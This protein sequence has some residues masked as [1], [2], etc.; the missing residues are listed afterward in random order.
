MKSSK[1][2]DCPATG[3]IITSAECGENRQTKYACPESCPF[4]PWS[5]EN[6]DM[7]NEIYDSMKPKMYDLIGKEGAREMETF[8]R[9]KLSDETAV[10]SQGALDR[11]LHFDLDES[12]RSRMQVWQEQNWNGLKN[13]GKLQAESLMKM[14]ISLIEVHHIKNNRLSE[15]V[16]LLHPEEPPILISDYTLA[17]ISSRFDTFL[18]LTYPAP[19][20]TRLH[21]L[22]LPMEGAAG[23]TTLEVVCAIARHLGGPDDLAAVSSWIRKNTHR[24]WQA[25][26]E[27][28]ES[29]YQQKMKGVDARRT[30]TVYKAKSE[31]APEII[32]VLESIPDMERREPYEFELEIG[33]YAAFDYFD[34]ITLPGGGKS[35]IGSVA[36]RPHEIGTQADSG[37]NSAKLKAAFEQASGNLA[38]F[39]REI[40]EDLSA[41]L[42]E[43]H[44]GSKTTFDLVPK[45]LL[46]DPS[47]IVFQKQ[48]FDANPGISAEKF[49]DH[50]Y[51]QHHRENLSHP[52]PMLDGKTPLEAAKDPALRDKLLNWAKMMINS[53]DKRNL[54]KGRSVEIDWLTEELGLSEIAFP[55]PPS[56]IPIPSSKALGGDLETEALEDDESDASDFI[57]PP[58]LPISPP[59]DAM[60]LSEDAAVNRMRSILKKDQQTEYIIERIIHEAPDLVQELKHL[61][62]DLEIASVLTTMTAAYVWCILCPEGTRPANLEPMDIHAFFDES[63]QI[64]EEAATLQDISVVT[65]TCSEPHVLALTSAVSLKESEAFIKLLPYADR[66]NAEESKMYLPCIAHSVTELI[67]EAL[68]RKGAR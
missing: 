20:Y 51:L 26:G 62:E 41:Q 60:P 46:S 56:R 55:A 8:Y 63:L 27:L 48:R 58:K 2:R 36:C 39:D 37:E 15:V 54:Q 11:L 64:L 32:K 13:D 65:N 12:G 28:S 30:T 38:T 47:Q 24:F 23:K 43:K 1:K 68:G 49:E 7:A 4:N 18:A 59:L 33:A 61:S 40:T 22:A 21:G 52:I 9:R 10:Q 57:T 29:Q 45:E 66:K 17:S 53:V 34:P 67:C 19:H 42:L 6:Y 35:L 5:L 16:D 44:L 3:G 31:A 50:C 14:R 25:I